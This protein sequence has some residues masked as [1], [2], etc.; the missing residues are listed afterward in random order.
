MLA[1]QKIVTDASRVFERVTKPGRE[2]EDN[3]WS[4]GSQHPCPK[5]M[6]NESFMNTNTASPY[7]LVKVSLN[8]SYIWT[9][10]LEIG[11]LTTIQGLE[12]VRGCR[13][14]NIIGGDVVEV[15]L[16]PQYFVPRNI[17]K[18][19]CSM[20]YSNT[21][22]HSCLL[23]RW[24]QALAFHAYNV[25]CYFAFTA[26]WNLFRRMFLSSTF[27]VCHVDLVT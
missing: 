13:G 27:Y 18:W 20:Y 9:G 26:Q 1:R 11:G 23:S 10:A 7:Y 17:F 25:H 8:W 6:L 16:K 15:T 3:S 4:C 2:K 12:V 5:W 24:I 21:T 22:Y 19:H 14:L